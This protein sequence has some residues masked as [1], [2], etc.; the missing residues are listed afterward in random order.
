MPLHD[1]LIKS[2]LP[3]FASFIGAAEGMKGMDPRLACLLD[4]VGKASSKVPNGPNIE[5]E[6]MRTRHTP[7]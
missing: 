3:G 7:A 6:R 5:D 4:G 2:D 1:H